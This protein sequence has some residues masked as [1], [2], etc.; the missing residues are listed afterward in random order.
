MGIFDFIIKLIGL[1]K[2]LTIFLVVLKQKMIFIILSQKKC[3]IFDDYIAKSLMLLITLIDFS[4]VL[5]SSFELHFNLRDNVV[6]LEGLFS[7]LGLKIFGLI[8]DLN[9]NCFSDYFLR[10]VLSTASFSLTIIH[11]QTSYLI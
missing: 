1:R 5:S 10:A 7:D 2:N 8:D 9:N 4:L 6:L 3:S 11:I